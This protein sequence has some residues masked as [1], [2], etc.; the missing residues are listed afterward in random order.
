MLFMNPDKLFLMFMLLGIAA[1][2]ITVLV[3][4]YL[5]EALNVWEKK[6]KEDRKRPREIIVTIRN[7]SDQDKVIKQIIQSEASNDDA[8]TFRERSQRR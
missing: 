4:Y 8:P 6:E 5:L 1:I 3:G 7:E 2:I